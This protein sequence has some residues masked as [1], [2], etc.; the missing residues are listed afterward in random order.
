MD[1]EIRQELGY[2][3][4]AVPESCKNVIALLERYLKVGMPKKWDNT[5]LGYKDLGADVRNKTIDDYRLWL[6]KRLEEIE[7]DL[8]ARDIQFEKYQDGNMTKRLL[9]SE[10]ADAIREHL[11]GKINE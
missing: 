11:I 2:L 9:I 8:I 3:K 6:A 5:T 1:K 7:S 10:I 4:Q